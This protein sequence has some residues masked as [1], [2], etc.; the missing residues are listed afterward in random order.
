MVD[1]PG[2]A[3]RPVDPDPVADL[4]AEQLVAGHAQRLGLG[5]EQGILDGAERL[6][7]D[8]AG[9]GTRRPVEIGIDALVLADRLADDAAAQLVDDRGQARRAEPFRKLAP[10]DDAL[11]RRELDEVVVAPAGIA[12]QRL[13]A[14]DFH[15]APPVSRGEPSMGRQAWSDRGRCTARHPT[16]TTRRRARRPPVARPVGRKRLRPR[17]GSSARGFA[18]KG[19]GSDGI[20][21]Q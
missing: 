1:A 5:V 17:S 13:Y 20:R 2:G 6:G 14:R 4:A 12:G 15:G 9:A 11:V 7:D 3:V 18:I 8:A 10:A 19:G 21:I 16:G